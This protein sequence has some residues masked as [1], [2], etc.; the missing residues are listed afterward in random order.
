M[1]GPDVAHRQR[2][3]PAS[4]IANKNPRAFT[5]HSTAAATSLLQALIQ[6]QDG[7]MAKCKA[8]HQRDLS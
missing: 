1:S 8:T 6:E 5:L 7:L 4:A 2:Q 3:G